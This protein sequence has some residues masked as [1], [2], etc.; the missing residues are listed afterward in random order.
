MIA[1]SPLPI[2]ELKLS[3]NS[4]IVVS[5]KANYHTDQGDGSLAD[6]SKKI[7]VNYDSL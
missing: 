7:H 3:S 2:N 1:I 5:T 4:W 6:M